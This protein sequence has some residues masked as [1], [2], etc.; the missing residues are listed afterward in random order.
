MPVD[1]FAPNPWGLYQVH[2]NVYDWVED[3]WNATYQGAPRDCSARVTGNC[4]RR[5]LRGG[6]WYDPPEMLRAA[7]RAGFFPAYRSDK[8]GF[9]VARSL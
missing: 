4:Q 2:G 7:H 1:Q 6:S 8:I 9:R 5:V 3:C